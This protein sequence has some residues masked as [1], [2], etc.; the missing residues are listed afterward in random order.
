VSTLTAEQRAKLPRSSFADPARRLFPV[1]DDG[2]VQAA[3]LLLGKAK[4]PAAVKA[5]VILIAR[6]RGLKLPAAWEA[7]AKAGEGTMRSALK[8]AVNGG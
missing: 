6:K 2:D 8:S 1:I 3:A 4:N 5:R 7:D